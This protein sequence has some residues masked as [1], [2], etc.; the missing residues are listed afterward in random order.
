MFFPFGGDDPP[1][2]NKASDAGSPAKTGKIASLPM[3]EEAA[4]AATTDKRPQVNLSTVICVPWLIGLT[5]MLAQWGILR[6]G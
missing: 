1:A 2:A 5:I 6:R 3:D 4:L